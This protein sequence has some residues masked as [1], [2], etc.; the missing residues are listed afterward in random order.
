MA[1]ELSLFNTGAMPKHVADFFAEEGSNIADRVT[2]PSLT[3]GG[4][5]WAIGLNGEQTKV[6]KKDDDGDLVPVS[7]MR[8]VILAYAPRRGRAYYEGAYDPAKP[9]KPLCWSDDGVAPDA[10]IAEP[11][12][13]KCDGCQQA[14]KGSR[15][16]DNGKSATACSQ[17]R[18]LVVVPAHKLDFTPLRLKLAV[19]SDYDGQSPELE[20]QGWFAFSNYLD[21][22]RTR[23]VQHTAA[24]VTKMKFDPN[25][26]YP[27]VIFSPDKWLE[28]EQ[29]KLVTP[30][31]K[32]DSVQSLLA[33]TWTPAGADGKQIEH[34]PQADTKS[35]DADAEAKKAAATTKAE[36]EA[37]KAA[38]ADADTK[39]ATAAAKKAAKAE[40]EAK[41]EAD[42]KAKAAKA[43]ADDDGEIVLP[44][45]TKAVTETAEAKPKETKG[46]AAIPDDVAALLEE[47]GD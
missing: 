23:G 31:A 3:Y 2:V 43:A 45:D 11:P 40:A 6:Q 10:S 42:K 33:G 24:L 29:I 18:M 30:I 35:A 13:S 27:K 25:V 7:V 8:V 36:A 21:L 5:V 47:W 20:A 15:V 22:L 26:D 16:S 41:A 1:N 46:S 17:H 39:A 12:H 37:K 9:G 32:S 38:K 14:I 34:K 19:T 4:K 44:G 28:A